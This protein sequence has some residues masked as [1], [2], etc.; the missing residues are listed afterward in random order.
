MQYEK[1]FEIFVWFLNFTSKGKFSK[2]ESLSFDHTKVFI[3]PAVRDG[4]DLW[5]LMGM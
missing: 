5:V 2:G 4:S 1:K 3:I